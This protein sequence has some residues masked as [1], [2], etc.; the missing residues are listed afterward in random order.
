MSN[1]ISLFIFRRDLRLEDNTGLIS[2]LNHGGRVIPCFIL[3]KRLL[4]STPSKLKNNNAIQFMLESLKD[5]DRQLKQKNTRLHLFF[6]KVH[7]I[8]EEL[9]TKEEIESVHFNSDYTTFSKKRDDD[10]CDICEK[11][12][13]K[14][15]RF[16]KGPN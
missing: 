16:L 15:F 5:L 8:I 13:M 1:E 7:E 14:C 9:I 12:K 2:A 11:R 6:G 10:I 4:E 3:D